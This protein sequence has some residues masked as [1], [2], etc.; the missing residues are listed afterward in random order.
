[1]T[2]DTLILG[3]NPAWQRLFILDKFVPGEVNRLPKAE[4]YASGKGINCGRILQLLGGNPILAHFLGSEHGVRIFDE[5]A[6]IGIR[7]I[8]VWINALTRICTTIVGNGDTT[9]LIEPS[10][11]LSES[12]NDD[13]LQAI[14]DCW[15]EVSRIVLC[16]SFPDNFHAEKLFSLDLTGKRLYIDAVTGVDKW[17]GKGSVAL[18]KLN[19]G[20]Y[21]KLLQQQGIPQVT[22]SPQFWKMTASTL[23][24]KLPVRNL[25]VTD[26]DAPVRAF[27]MEE[28]KLQYWMLTPPKVQ[29]V[30]DVGAGDSFLAGYLSAESDELPVAN[31]LARATAVAA[32][33][34]EADRP[35]NLNLERASALEQSL[36]PLVEKVND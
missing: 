8:P 29:V 33:R 15:T 35:W 14:N 18:L 4:E 21:C 25:I 7:Q 13:F 26:E 30:N 19:M 9:E 23:L 34:C 20:E 6:A 2:Q 28:G 3:L 12:E 24:G 22:S 32:A 36:V 31:C 17:L 5:I 11:V 10:P 16:G 1:M 27:R